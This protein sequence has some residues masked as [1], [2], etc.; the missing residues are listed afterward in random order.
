MTLSWFLTTEHICWILAV[1]AAFLLGIIFSRGLTT[2]SNGEIV[3]EE[4]LDGYSFLQFKL[5]MELDEI[6]NSEQIIFSVKTI[7]VNGY[8]GHQDESSEE[9]KFSQSV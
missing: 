4:Y 1:I 3:I 8:S 6:K 9:S 5:P 7:K 2:K